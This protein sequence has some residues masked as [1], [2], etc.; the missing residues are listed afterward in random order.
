MD[1]RD[2]RWKGRGDKVYSDFTNRP[3]RTGLKV[4]AVLVAV[5]LALGAIAAVGS[6][7]GA[8]GGEAKRIVSPQNVREQNGAIIDAWEAMQAQAAN[9]CQVA[10]SPK[11]DGD[12]TLIED[13]ALAYKALYRSSAAGYNARMADIYRAQLVRKVPVPSNLRSYPERAPTLEA[14]QRRVC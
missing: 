10:S 2:E 14:M 4:F 3:V 13:P 1:P 12:P 9:A 6:F 5:G 11:E 8:W 7:V